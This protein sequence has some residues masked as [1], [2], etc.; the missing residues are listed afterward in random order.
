MKESISLVLTG[1]AGQGIQIIEEISVEMFKKA[2]FY[3]FATKK[4]MSRVRGGINST[5]I[6]ISSVNKPRAYCN[7]I[8]I[9][10]PFKV[11]GYEKNKKRLTKNSYI[12]I[13]KSF[14]EE[15]KEDSGNFLYIPFNKMS[16]EAG[17][18]IYTNTIAVGVLSG[19]L[20]LNIESA[21]NIISKKFK[22]KAKKIIDNN[23]EA[24]KIGF[25]EGKKYNLKFNL[26]LEKLKKG[27]DIVLNGSES[28]ALG[29]IAG[30][31]NFVSAYPMSPSTE[32][33]Q[34][35]ASMAEDFGIVVEQIEDEISAVNMSIG[36]WFAGARGLITTSG[37]GF[38]LMSEGLSLAGMI[39]SPLVIHLAQRPGPATGLPTR[40]EQGDLNLAVY[41]GHGEFPRI[42][43]APG[44]IEEGFDL[45]QKAFNLADKYQ[46]PVM[47][48]TDQYFV[49]SYYN[50]KI[51]EF[52]KIENKK[53]FIKSKEDY[54]RHE[55]TKNGLS[56]RAIPGFGK[57]IV[58]TTGNEHEENGFITE[59]MNIRNSM[60]E[61]RLCKLEL[62]KEKMIEPT[63]Y[64]N[65]NAEFLFLSW[66]STFNIIK[67]AFEKL[68]SKNVALL[69][70]SQVYPLSKNIYKYFNN[71]KQCYVVEN[72]STSQFRKLLRTELNLNIDGSILKYDGRPFSAEGIYSKIKKIING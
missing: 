36:A 29:A 70:F 72:N 51:P 67:E 22:N 53:Y 9:L 18:N 52:D 55:I 64:G 25:E 69:H 63:F 61:K 21:K 59:D 43:L 7:N 54:K 44:T 10:I 32:V 65:K 34:I 39:E 4:Y 11:G 15:I 12:L 49:S 16:K 17:G 46:V 40:T 50:L 2:G 31:C 71:S 33:L 24:F 14:K 23:L 27:K 28:I 26:K 20:N 13:D 5:E 19:I 42:V 68:N 41:S 57:G 1:A 47:I 62:L 35:C 38:A 37:G 48:L 56:K 30:G 66:G 58:K 3:V 45:T 60:Q 8:D 6:R